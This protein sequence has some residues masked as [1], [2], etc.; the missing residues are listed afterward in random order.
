MTP[1]VIAL[2][3]SAALIL[4][5]IVVTYFASGPNK[6]E[7]IFLRLL[8]IIIFLNILM[9]IPSANLEKCEIA[10]NTSTV[11]YN[12]TSYTYDYICFIDDSG[13]SR[14][15]FTQIQY[16]YYAF[17]V[18]ILLYLS[19]KWLTFKGIIGGKKV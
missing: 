4:A 17:W 5:F 6:N 3:I 2:G 15:Y 11:N 9:I 14:G 8:F 13:F 1:T 19:W 7:H 16:M 18:Y 10:V 12:T